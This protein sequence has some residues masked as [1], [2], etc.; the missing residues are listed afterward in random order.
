[1]M[2]MVTKDD[3]VNYSNDTCYDVFVTGMLT[4]TGVP[5]DPEVGLL[6]PEIFKRP[7]FNPPCF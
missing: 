3:D 2:M 1:M 6:T 7:H 5:S 4:M